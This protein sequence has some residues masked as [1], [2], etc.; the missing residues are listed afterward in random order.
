MTFD[1]HREGLKVKAK[2]QSIVYIITPQL[3]MSHVQSYL[4]L[5]NYL[6]LV[7]FEEKPSNRI[8]K[9]ALQHLGRHVIGRARLRA[10]RL[11]L[12]EALREPEVDDLQQILLHGPLG[13][14]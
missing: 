6:K 5:K 11:A 4:P 9:P 14:E 12:L 1:G 2:A 8:E 7:S 13:E 3:Q 10:H